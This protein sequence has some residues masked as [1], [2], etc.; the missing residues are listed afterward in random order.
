MSQIL[1]IIPS[2]VAGVVCSCLMY[3][4]IFRKEIAQRDQLLQEGRALAKDIDQ[5]ITYNQNLVQRMKSLQ[6][7]IAGQY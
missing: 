6:N 5:Q 4:W 3:E 2:F 1:I 7:E